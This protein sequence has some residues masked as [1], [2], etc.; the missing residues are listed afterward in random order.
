MSQYFDGGTAPEVHENPGLAATS[1]GGRHP[2]RLQPLT[3]DSVLNSRACCK[4]LIFWSFLTTLASM[5]SLLYA[6][7]VHNSLQL[8]QGSMF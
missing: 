6:I 8:R 7:D 2:A 4:L 1:G 5:L 3:L